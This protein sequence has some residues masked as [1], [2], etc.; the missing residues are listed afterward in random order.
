MNFKKHRE[1]LVKL[2]RLFTFY[3]AKSGVPQQFHGFFAGF[4]I[5]HLVNEFKKPKLILFQFMALRHF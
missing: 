2:Q 5:D 3:L 4:E 1:K